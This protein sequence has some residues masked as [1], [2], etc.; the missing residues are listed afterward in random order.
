MAVL[1]LLAPIWATFRESLTISEPELTP[2]Q[3][4]AVFACRENMMLL[5][6]KGV[7]TLS[8]QG[9]DGEQVEDIGSG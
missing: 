2:A 1:V 5:M 3:A 4:A 8:P 6:D 7:Q 9:P